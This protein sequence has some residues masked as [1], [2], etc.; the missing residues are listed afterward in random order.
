MLTPI[1]TV[2]ARVRAVYSSWGRDTSPE[3]MRADWDLLFGAA[4]VDAA[5]EHEVLSG[6]PVARITAPGANPKRLFLYFHGGGYLVGSSRSHADLVARIS[7]VADATGLCVEYRRA[8]EHQ[9]PAPVDD[10]LAVCAELT[11]RGVDLGR[12]AFLGDSAGGNL[13]LATALA[14]K[15]R[16]ETLP[17]ALVLLSPWTDLEAR[18]ESYRTRAEADPIHQRRMVLAMASRYLGD[19]DPAQPLASPL[20]ADLSGLPPMLIQV[21]DRETVL[22]DATDLQAAADKAGVEAELQVWDEMIHV[23]QQFS[24]D[25]PQAREAIADIGRF[26]APRLDEVREARP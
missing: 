1:D 3:Q 14:L 11:R 7:A 12:T 10:A 19:A 16:G 15:D 9:F 25:L 6:V 4:P 23:F 8:P 2:I 24:Q 18:G 20:N 26:L 22:S 21:G 5:I 13:A 17:G